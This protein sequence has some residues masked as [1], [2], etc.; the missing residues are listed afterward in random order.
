MLEMFEKVGEGPRRLEKIVE[1]WLTL[2]KVGAVGG[3]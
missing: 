2:N 3:G 1:G